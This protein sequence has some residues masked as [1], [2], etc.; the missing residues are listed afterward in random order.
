MNDDSVVK[1]M[2]SLGLDYNP[3]IE[4]TLKFQKTVAELNESLTDMKANAIQS[5]KDINT[6]YSSQLGQVGNKTI[7]DQY[8]NAFKT[9]KQYAKEATNETKNMAN[10]IKQ[11]ALEQM[12]A[13][14]ASVQ[15]KLY[16]RDL[17]EEY[18]KQAGTLREQLDVTLQ[19][20][21]AEG[22]LNAEDIKRTKELK[23]QLEILKGQ[24]GQEIA[25]SKKI[26][27]TGFGEEWDR[28]AGWF[29]S[30]QLF[31]GTINAAKE[32]K[33][34]IKNVE[35][36]MVEIGRVM[37]DSSFVFTDYRDNL[38]QLGIDYGQTFENVQQIALRWAQSGYN[39]VDSL[40]L[41]ETSLLALNT[42]E[43][44]AKN[45]TESMIGIMAQWQLQ[46]DDMA[47]VM[48]KINITADRY[49]VTS[50]DLVDG[51][52]RSSGAA[53]NMN[54]E[55]DETIA[56]LTVMR[57]ASGRTGREVGNALNSILSYI[58]R[59]KSIETLEGLGIQMF[60]DE[61]KT[62]FRNAMDIFKDIHASWG[63]LSMDIQDGFVAAAD[64]AGLFNEEL[65]A[66]LDLEKEWD[67]VQKRDVSQ[68]AA[69]THR[70]NYFIGM[71]ERMANAQ[72]VLNNM[73]DAEGYSMNENANTM[74]TLEKK[75]ESLK[76]SAEQLAV[77]I[78]DAGLEGALKGIIESGTNAINVINGLPK[79]MRDLLLASTSMFIAVKTV[80]L[81]LKTF[82][83]EIPGIHQMIESLTS[84]TWNLSKA[85]KAGADGV[86]AFVVANGPLLALSAVVGVITAV[87]NHIK[88]QREE[89]ERAI[90][91]FNQQ[92]DVYAEVNNLIPIYKDL[93]GATSLTAE[94]NEKLVTTKQKIIDLLP[95][96]QKF[97]E[98]EN[99]SLE[100]QVGII[101]DLN[102]AEL[103]SLRIN[104]Q[105]VINENASSYEKDK[106]EL[107]EQ[108]KLYE[109][110]LQLLK[111]LQR[112]EAEIR[113]GN[114]DAYLSP[115]Q[116]EDLKVL[117]G[118]IE[119]EK[120]TVGNLE[121]NVSAY[122][123]AVETLNI[124]SGVMGEITEDNTGKNKDNADSIKD[125]VE[126]MDELIGK[127]NDA[128][129]KLQTYYGILDELN[130]KEGLSAKSKQDIITKYSELMPYLSDE[131][132][133]RRQLIQVIAQEEETQRKAY[134][135]MIVTSEGFYNAKIKGTDTLYKTLGEFYTKDLEN[136]KSLAEAKKIV[137]DSLIKD[138][139]GMWAKYYNAASSNILAEADY[140]KKLAFGYG[141]AEETAAM[142]AAI[143]AIDQQKEVARRFEE[144]ANGFSGGIDFK[145]IN[146]SNVKYPTGSKGSKDKKDNRQVLD[147]ID[148]EIRAIKI[149]NDGLEKSG[150]LLQDQ[151]NI[152]KDTEGIEG[153]NEQYKLTGDLIA[154]NAQL[155]MSF[156][157]EQASVHDMADKIRETYSNF[158]IDSWFDSNAEMT[159]SYTE[160]FNNVSKAQQEEMNKVF[161]QVQKLKKAWMESANEI[162]KANENV[163]QLTVSQAELVDQMDKYLEQHRENARKDYI[164]KQNKLY[165]EQQE[166]LSSLE[167]IQEK[168]VQIIRKRG[169]EERKALDEAHSA[170]MESLEERHSERKKKYADDL[171]LFRENIQAK[172]D[173]LE[174]QWDEEDYH[175]N[176]QKE[177]EKADELQ[178]QI[179]SLSL[180]D[181][182]TA[183]NKVIDLRKQLAEQNEKIAK[184]QQDRERK[185][186][187]ES[188]QDQL[189]EYEE[190][191][192]E[193][194]DI[195]DKTY[196]NEKKRLE[197]EYRINQQ[198]LD[199]KYSDEKVYAEARKSI[200][201]GQVEVSKGVFM[202]IYDAFV[203][204]E[205]K[206]GKGMGIL[207][208]VIRDDFI[209]QLELAQRAIDELDYKASNL[210]KK[211]DSDYDP[212]DEEMDYKPPKSSRGGSSRGG[213]L[214]RMSKSDY[215]KYV[216]Y[217]QIYDS[218]RAAGNKIAM[219]SAEQ[220]AQ[221]LRDKYGIKSD[222]YSYNDLKNL[223]YDKMKKKGYMFGGK[224]DFTGPTFVHGS[225]DRPEYIFNYPQFKDLAKMI[226]E[227][228]FI[229]G[230]RNSP[231]PTPQPS[232]VL[233]VG[234]LV[235]I[236]GN[237]TQE[238]VPEIK[239]VALEANQDLVKKLNKS[240]IYGPAW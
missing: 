150:K 35:M 10:Q 155:L 192:K 56:L 8:G 113:S 119:D 21:R 136:A 104:A 38:M 92:K 224:A 46:A 47:L 233:Q 131:Q 234:S 80:H 196:E 116:M 11:S 117:P 145:G 209:N 179:D 29:L 58:T 182:L 27:S 41:T 223:S 54:M 73:I 98:D 130:S 149:R 105:K 17:N 79:P 125:Q 96:S 82:G 160:Q 135:E 99:L 222:K 52:L 175:E 124:V 91:V 208:D 218:A 188:L 193:K 37:T 57:E 139:S 151:I 90:E 172:I 186:T 194:E 51:L 9:A 48:D 167:S 191:A 107:E 64:E 97:I 33:E 16:S 53:R 74:E 168:I 127:F 32:A 239:E 61:T 173:E 227:E 44:D 204:F 24:A 146:L 140:R 235:R 76:T 77:A 198:Y 163:R 50:Q 39:V 126:A 164:E 71:I 154:H 45:A 101:E 93:A 89:Q 85:F 220:S 86:K 40:K 205:N 20:L 210:R 6:A 1:I 114:Q 84:G 111:D 66:T 238:T 30:G 236:D 18:I 211:Y 62:Q 78:G 26:Q 219:N 12:K 95:E 159:T 152:A 115:E 201:R 3:A 15:Q 23:E 200:M 180:D 237:V 19:K 176:L 166:R 183:R 94:Q 100:E 214:S 122:E 108:T 195:A 216:N 103:E 42:A 231:F 13:Q 202:D 110:H 87:T 59:E 43:L 215:N 2:Q 55:L 134:N 72:D 7:V 34:T 123:S 165:S 158:N 118:L 221:A 109:E 153:L 142:K 181:S 157:N 60:T 217:K 121:K 212:T 14:A 174:D 171:D 5:A 128:T 31:Y 229:S 137:E 112:I 232:V 132:E 69:G 184:M 36:G 190:N 207:G 170:E 70:R 106:K 203:D 22:Q 67:D 197:E 25:D 143:N 178:K 129:S 75:M 141:T 138:L 65:A 49:S 102:V 63:S 225:P 88:K 187:K 213:S 81:G 230:N 28:R 161:T 185:L 199:R 162:D 83:V 4:S 206:F 226:A 148:A 169:E 144:L 68:S 228:R 147:S 120:E 189:K 133:L 240:G 177:K 156:K